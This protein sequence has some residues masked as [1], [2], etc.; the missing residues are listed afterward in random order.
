MAALGIEPKPGG[1]ELSMHISEVPC[2]PFIFVKISTKS[3]QGI[4]VKK[5]KLSSVQ[6]YCL[7]KAFIFA[8]KVIL[9]KPQKTTTSK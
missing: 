9:L 6:L 7:I 2:L 8:G 4:I 3:F 5:K 1:K